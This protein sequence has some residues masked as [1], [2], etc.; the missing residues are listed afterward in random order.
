MA[1]EVINIGKVM[2]EEATARNPAYL[3][4]PG[5]MGFKVSPDAVKEV[6]AFIRSDLD[7]MVGKIVLQLKAEGRKTILERDIVQFWGK[8]G[9]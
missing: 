3:P 9:L 8:R 6:I 2:R 4:V 1:T 5:N 7:V